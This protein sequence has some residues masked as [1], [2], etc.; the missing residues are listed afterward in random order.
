MKYLQELEE[1]LERELMDL[2]SGK[3]EGEDEKKMTDEVSA[4]KFS[5]IACQK[6]RSKCEKICK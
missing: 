2:E 5:K 6:Y 3:K 1:E 4:S